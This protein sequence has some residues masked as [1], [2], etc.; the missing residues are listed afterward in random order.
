MATRTSLRT[1]GG[2]R[3]TGRG[4]SKKTRGRRGDQ[5]EY[6]FDYSLLFIVLFLLGFGMIMIYSASSYA[7][8][9]TYGDA[10]YYLKKQALAVALG[11]VAMLVVANIPYH[12]WERF[13]VLGYLLSVALI[14]MVLT[15]LGIESHGARRWFKIPG[16]GMQIQP[17][18]VAKLAMILFLAVM[19]CK[20]GKS[21]GTMKGLIV[22]MLM[23]MPI[24]VMIWKITDNLSSAIIV[25]SISFL[26]VFVALPGLRA[27]QRDTQRRDD[28]LS[29]V[30][31]VKK[32]QT[33]NRGALPTG[34]G[35]VVHG[36][37][38]AGDN[39][40]TWQ[41][42]YDK[43]LGNFVDP[44]GEYYKLNVIGC[45][46]A[47][48]PG[49]DCEGGDLEDKSFSENKYTILVVTKAKCS[50]SRAV[51]VSNPRNLAVLYRLEGSGVYCTST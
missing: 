11:L 13:A 16:I 43:Y 22:M 6:F 33:N 39:D 7:A 19:V 2:R 28:M 4:R 45:N 49:V 17:A 42:F 38:S 44:D 21:V 30:E 29:F 48:E 1:Q 41:G 37:E 18:E 20:M 47:N 35:E 12:V 40:N 51:R 23:P 3:N 8:F 36:G 14:L 25:L 26:M 31:T 27:S 32:Y 24:V 15:P 34:I 5:S 50:G 10:A 46:G 9:Q